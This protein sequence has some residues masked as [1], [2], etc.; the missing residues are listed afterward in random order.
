MK[1][2]LDTLRKAVN[3]KLISEQLAIGFHKPVQIHQGSHTSYDDYDD[4]DSDYEDFEDYDDDGYEDSDHH[5]EEEYHVK[6]GDE[7]E[8]V[9]QNLFQLSVYAAKLHDMMEEGHDVEEWVQEKIIE[10]NSK[11][12]DVYHYL[13]Y[14]MF[15]KSR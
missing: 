11:I 14:E 5:H 6:G 10:A 7:L 4:M 8:M 12:S 9:K 15:K 3:Q 13:E 2:D 1:I